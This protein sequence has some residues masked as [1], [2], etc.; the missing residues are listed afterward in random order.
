MHPEIRRC[1]FY[2]IHKMEFQ[3]ISKQHRKTQAIAKNHSW[4]Y[5]QLN[6]S[7]ILK[8]HDL[9]ALFIARSPIDIIQN[10]EII[11]ENIYA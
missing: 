1:F 8:R 9:N 7:K 11:Q 4:H 3:V 5:K 10:E 2:T 6:V